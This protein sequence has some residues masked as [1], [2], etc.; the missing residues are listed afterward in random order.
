MSEQ[1]SDLI[2]SKNTVR[3]IKFNTAAPK[4]FKKNGLVE[5][6]WGTVAKLTNTILL[7]ARLN[8]KIFY[9]AVK[10]TQYIHDILPVRELFDADGFPTTPYDLATNR[11]PSSKHFK[12]F[13]CP[14]IFKQYETYEKGKVVKNKYTQQGTCG[15]FVGVPDDSAGWLFYVPDCKKTYIS[16]DTVFDEQFTAPLCLPDLPYQGAIR[17]RDVKSCKPNSDPIIKHTGDPSGENK[18][19]PSNT[20]LPTPKTRRSKFDL[21]YLANCRTSGAVGL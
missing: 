12:I 10:Y 1:N 3:K 19:Y 8:R 14:A 15:I 7:H 18:Q 11:N 20:D 6:H 13:G 5:R 21:V 17:L 2:L 9:Y 4:H 16:M